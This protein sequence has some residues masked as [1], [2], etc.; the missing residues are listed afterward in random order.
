MKISSISPYAY[1]FTAKLKD[2]AKNASA[3]EEY[4]DNAQIK[5]NDGTMPYDADVQISK[6]DK[7]GNISSEYFKDGQYIVHETISTMRHT[8]HPFSADYQEIDVFDRQLGERTSKRRYDNGRVDILRHGRWD[9]K[10][11]YEIEHQDEN[12][13]T[14]GYTRR[15][16]MGYETGLPYYGYDFFC[17]GD[18][19]YRY[20]Q[21][22]FDKDH[23]PIGSFEGLET[24]PGK[25][26][27]SL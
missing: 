23:N 12:G 5:F 20:F 25:R 21:S 10:N 14:T 17:M 4:E 16:Y 1:N 26:I 2:R 15:E 18:I 19:Y 13:E 9:S 22:R 11:Y 6:T 7:D 8:D 3:P 24:I 27:Q